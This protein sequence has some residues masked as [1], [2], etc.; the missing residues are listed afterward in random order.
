MSQVNRNV[1]PN[2]PSAKS[3]DTGKSPEDP[4]EIRKIGGDF[5]QVEIGTPTK[6]SDPSTADVLAAIQMLTSDFRS[7]NN[8]LNQ[9]EFNQSHADDEVA[10][11]RSKIRESLEG[12]EKREFLSVRESEK[13]RNTQVAY[14]PDPYGAEREGEY[15]YLG[16]RKI[17]KTPGKPMYTAVVSQNYVPNLT[18]PDDVLGQDNPFEDAF[19]EPGTSG[20]RMSLTRMPRAI[21]NVV[22]ANTN[23]ATVMVTPYEI[24]ENDKMKFITLKSIKRMMEQYA[25]FKASSL[26]NT[27]TL[28]FFIN[29]ECQTKLIAKQLLLEN[30][31]SKFITPQNVF[32]VS[33]SHVEN[34]LSDYVRPTSRDEFVTQFNQ[35]MTHPAWRKD[36]EFNTLNYYKDIFPHVTLFLEECEIYDEYLRRGA[37]VYDLEN[38][39]KLEWGKS[40]PGGMFRIAVAILHP[41]QDNFIQILVEEKLKKIYSMKEF[42]KYFT[43]KNSEISQMSLKI[44]RQNNSMK[45]PAS[46]SSIAAQARKKSD[47]YKEYRTKATKT[48]PV[49]KAYTHYVKNRLN[50]IEGIEFDFPPEEEFTTDLID[51]SEDEGRDLN[52]EEWNLKWEEKNN[53]KDWVADQLRQWDESEVQLALHALCAIEPTYTPRRNHEGTK[54]YQ[55]KPVNTKDQ[56]CFGYAFGKCTAGSTCVYSHDPTKIKGFLK[57]SYERL[58]GAPAWDSKIVTDAGTA[59]T[60]N[61]SGSDH[62]DNGGR[63]NHGGGRGRGAF[64]SPAANQRSTPYSNNHDKS[65][66]IEVENTNGNTEEKSIDIPSTGAKQPLST[67]WSG[68]SRSPSTSGGRENPDC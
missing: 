68:S 67:E 41:Y 48:A 40:E 1:N 53:H 58:L 62:R 49:K 59:R 29:Q 4:A 26:D 66:I 64:Q 43:K 12:K 16:A 11:L 25:V 42:I 8:R 46:Y 33:D 34:M 39:P 3:G 21:P 37:P 6:S 14:Y 65:Y 10:G 51:S 56:V 9:M 38:M 54:I 47:E 55:A 32:R 52:E 30:P 15:T 18:D 28:I 61:R 60:P 20:R 44:L 23:A 45:K 5:V 7:V 17:E 27:K 19:I 36:L 2:K 24:R 35:A 63:S 50:E 57:S 22:T 31:I 13:D